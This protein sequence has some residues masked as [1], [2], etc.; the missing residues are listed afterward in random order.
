MTDSRRL[1]QLAAQAVKDGVT[2]TEG[3]ELLTHMI[4]AVVEEDVPIF[5]YQLLGQMDAVIIALRAAFPL[6]VR[7]NAS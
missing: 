4:D 5:A 3:L 2:Y 6:E 1:A 7:E